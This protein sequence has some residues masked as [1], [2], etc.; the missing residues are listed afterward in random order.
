MVRAGIQEPEPNTEHLWV[1]QIPTH[2]PGYPSNQGR[3][4][5]FTTYLPPPLCLYL[6]R[7]NYAP[8]SPTAIVFLEWAWAVASQSHRPAVKWMTIPSLQRLVMSVKSTATP[9]EAGNG[10]TPMTW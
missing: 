1:S 9:N 2:H 5:P 4:S 3:V 8:P 6:M 10:E 7:T